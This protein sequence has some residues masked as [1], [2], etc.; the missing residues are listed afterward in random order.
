[1][2]A[3]ATLATGTTARADRAQPVPGDHL[4]L[5]PAE[6]RGRADFGWLD[7]RHTFSFG[8]YMDPRHMGFSNLR[9][10]NDDRVAG[11]GGFPMHPHRDAEIFSYV[12]DGALEHKDSMGHGS[13]VGAGGVQY[14]A[15]G[16]G[17]THSEFNPSAT[18]PMHFLQVWLLPEIRGAEPRYDTL[19]IPADAKS[20]KPFLFLSQDGRKG[21]LRTNA[22]ADV[23]AATLS[24][25][26]SFSVDIAEGRSGW[27]QVA[28]GN[29]AVNG[30]ELREGD[31]LGVTAAGRL[32]FVN[33][34]D[35][36]ILVFDLPA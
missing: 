23:Y 35:A 19:D 32:D 7:S 29:L 22:D 2:T 4:I 20:G 9:V 27:V 24:P 15:A 25:G 8:Q 16:S 17:V 11:G 1:M 28:R 21:S 3:A 6:E 18:D 12:L 33:G 30:V 31:G 10:I 5:R 36:E 34:A 13:T 26:Q 14:M